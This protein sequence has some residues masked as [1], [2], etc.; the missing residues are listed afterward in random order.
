M[1]EKTGGGILVEPDNVDSLAEGIFQLWRDPARNEE[2]GRKAAQG[3]REHYSATKM[4]QRA[5]EV[6]GTLAIKPLQAGRSR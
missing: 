1:V 2:L 5:A 3:V 4:A 6:Y